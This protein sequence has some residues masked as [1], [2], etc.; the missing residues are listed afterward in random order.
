MELCLII[1]RLACCVIVAMTT[2]RRVAR[3]INVTVDIYRWRKRPKNAD[4]DWKCF[5]RETLR[6]TELFGDNLHLLSWEFYAM[7]DQTT[8]KAYQYLLNIYN[9]L[10]AW[11]QSCQGWSAQLVCFLHS[12]TMYSLR[13]RLLWNYIQTCFNGYWFETILIKICWINF[14]CVM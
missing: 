6:E 4:L 8:V 10:P 12:S 3:L 5:A 1:W 9:K 11:N 7:Y 14:S 2:R 13:C